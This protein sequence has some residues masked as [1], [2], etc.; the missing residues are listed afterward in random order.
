MEGQIPGG[1]GGVFK[2]DTEGQK[3]MTITDLK[4][5]C[6]RKILE[7]A[8]EIHL[9]GN[10]TT[11]GYKRP[12]FFTEIIPHGYTHESLSYAKS[13][14]TFK[15]TLFESSHDEAYCLDIYEKVKNA[16]GMTLPAAGRKLLIGEISFEFIGENLNMLQITVEFDWMEKKKQ[17]ETQPLADE[18]AVAIE[19]RGV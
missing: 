13:G 6:N 14:A 1:G 18:I 9:Y 12:S 5:A 3:I 19:K 8:P 4:I 2:K 11:D 16:F 15:A 7:A 17:M 10:D